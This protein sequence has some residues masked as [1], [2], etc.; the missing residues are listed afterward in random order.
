MLEGIAFLAI[1]TA[2]VTSTFVARA[3]KERGLA[4]AAADEGEIENLEGRLDEMTNQLDWIETMLRQLGS[5]TP[6]GG[7]VRR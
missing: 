4:D 1:V 3:Q 5:P 2:A 7:W 6:R